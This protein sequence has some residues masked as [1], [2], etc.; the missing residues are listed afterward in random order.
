MDSARYQDLLQYL[1][2]FDEV[3]LDERLQSVEIGPRNIPKRRRR[4]DAIREGHL[5]ID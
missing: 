1:W 3:I 4:S 2:A 5:E